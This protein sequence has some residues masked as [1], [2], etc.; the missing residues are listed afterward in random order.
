MAACTLAM[1]ASLTSASILAAA[2]WSSR[3]RRS[4]GVKSSLRSRGVFDAA[5]CVAG[6]LVA[7]AG[8]WSALPSL[9]LALVQRP[10]PVLW[11][12]A[13]RPGSQAA[14][15]ATAI[16]RTGNSRLNMVEL[17]FDM[18]REAANL[19]QI[20]FTHGIKPTKVPQNVGWHP[21]MNTIWLLQCY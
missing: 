6:A 3:Q 4:N 8:R 1:S 19:R 16:R 9:A 14:S 10:V 11:R 17:L 13:A 2:R 18:G 20:A 21:F 5:A 7:A 12:A 15:N